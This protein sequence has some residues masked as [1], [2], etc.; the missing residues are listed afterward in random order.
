MKHF[1]AMEIYNGFVEVLE[2][3]NIVLL[4]EKFLIPAPAKM[5][6]VSQNQA[7]GSSVK[8]CSHGTETLSF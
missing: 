4:K 5:S 1:V 2:K 8:L 6:Y 7:S 3:G